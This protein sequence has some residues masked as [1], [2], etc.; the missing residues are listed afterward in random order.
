MAAPR[1]SLR[2]AV[3]TLAVDAA[4]AQVVRELGRRSIECVVLRGPAVARALYD[5]DELR[6][7]LDLDLLVPPGAK[8]AAGEA[9][10]GLGFTPVFSEADLA[11]HRPMHAY[12]WRR[13]ADHVSVDLHRTIDG[14][15]A[16]DVEVWKVFAESERT[17]VVAGERVALAGRAATLLGVVLHAAHH[18]RRRQQP[19]DDLTRALER[20][21][22][23]SWAEVAALAHRLDAVAAFS[24]G[25]RLRPEGAELA[26]RLGLP[27]SL[28][29]E[30]AL[31]ASAAPPLAL[32]M[33]WLART[34]G[35][36]AKIALIMHV[37]VPPPGAL[38][39]WRPL[40]RHGRRGLAAA[41]LSH[42][43]WLARFALPSFRALRRARR[44][45]A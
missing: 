18:G 5:A 41:Y 40:A 16:P 44:A 23:E 31:K 17:E 21:D 2:A 15:N 25:L 7:Y 22:L 10:A 26:D 27:T 30:V 19:V 33:E 34:P 39:A 32:G 29:L 37:L 6:P 35:L 28:P 9:L 13:E 1:S 43:F 12:E 3:Q 36:P 45:A 42:P 8:G 24:A 4:T 38:K 20:V 14:V 11:R